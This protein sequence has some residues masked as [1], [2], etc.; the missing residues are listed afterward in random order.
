MLTERQ[1]KTLDFIRYYIHKHGYA[2]KLP[3]I[4][5][6]IGIQSKGTVHRYVQALA[7]EGA[8][9]LIP[10]RHRGIQLRKLP[11][12]S[13]STQIP[14]LGK[15][16]AGK[17]IEAAVDHQELDLASFFVGNNLYALKVQ[18]DS[19]IEEG[20]F[21]GDIVICEQANTAKDGEIVVALIDGLEATL[22]N[23]RYQKDGTV[24]LIPANSALPALAYAAER[25]RIQGVFRGLIRFQGG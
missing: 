7:Q 4:A 18:G 23:I 17:P 11:I 6:G 2:P 25:V 19:M 13:H 16:A 21:D 5:Q 24:L 8:I 14:L 3:E 1:Q 10:H 9:D 12:T 22:K 20:I 15:I